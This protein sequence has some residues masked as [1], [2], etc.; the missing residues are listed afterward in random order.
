[1]EVSLTVRDRAAAEAS[2]KLSSSYSGRAWLTANIVMPPHPFY[3]GK[4]V[5][6]AKHRL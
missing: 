4:G 5:H 1:M 2:V 3:T 6:P